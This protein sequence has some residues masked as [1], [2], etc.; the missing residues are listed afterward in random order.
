MKQV[1]CLFYI[2]NNK[3]KKIILQMRKLA[4]KVKETC[5]KPLSQYV[6]DEDGCLDPLP[7]CH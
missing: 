3:K 5:P 6:A 7:V 4:Q 1:L 2:T